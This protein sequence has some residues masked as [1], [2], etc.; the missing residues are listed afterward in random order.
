MHKNRIHFYKEEGTWKIDLTS[1]FPI[2]SM[3]FKK[4]QQESGM[5]ENEYLFMLLE[6]LTGR[7]P[8]NEI[9]NTIE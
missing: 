9:W 6:M 2:G 4:M 7:K 5:D 8:G 3:A 1:L